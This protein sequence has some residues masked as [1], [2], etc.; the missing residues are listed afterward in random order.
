MTGKTVPVTGS[1]SGI[2]IPAGGCAARDVDRSGR[3]S[4]VSI[5]ARAA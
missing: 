1:T 2:G 3:A 5:P 4:L